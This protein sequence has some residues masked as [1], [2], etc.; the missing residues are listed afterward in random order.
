MHNFY[1]SKS[2]KQKIPSAGIAEMSAFGRR[3]LCVTKHSVYKVLIIIINENRNHLI[4]GRLLFS[5]PQAPTFSK[6]SA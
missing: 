1:N 6:Q 3:D 2:S 4:T 5:S